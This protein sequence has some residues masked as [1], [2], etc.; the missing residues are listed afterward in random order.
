MRRGGGGEG[1]LGVY[2]HLPLVGFAHTLGGGG[3]GGNGGRLQASDPR[4][5]GA[6][7]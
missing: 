4:D 5:Q 3:S 6:R 7:S 2:R 1:R